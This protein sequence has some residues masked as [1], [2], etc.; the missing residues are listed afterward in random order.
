MEKMEKP[1]LRMVQFPVYISDDLDRTK[2]L[3][4]T[5][6]IRN[7]ILNVGRTNPTIQASHPI[8]HMELYDCTPHT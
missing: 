8:N 1:G 6:R 7:Q 5:P 4:R 3:V 2:F